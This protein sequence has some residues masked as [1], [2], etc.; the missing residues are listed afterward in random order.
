VP[1]LAVL[2]SSTLR[3]KNLA[4]LVVNK[5]LQRVGHHYHIVIDAR[6]TK[7][8]K[9]IDH[10]LPP[11]LTPHLDEYLNNYRMRFSGAQKNDALWLS[12]KNGAMCPDA[13]GEAVRRR[14]RVSFGHAINVHLFRD[15]AASGAPHLGTS[16]LGHNKP[17]L[18]DQYY[19]RSDPLAASRKLGALIAT[20]RG[21][22]A[23]S[24]LVV[25]AGD[26]IGGAIPSHARNHREEM[27]A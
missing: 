4:A 13:V 8:H 12:S 9:P 25:C 26:S 23:T 19:R 15:I 1:S 21:N 3:R 20:L 10:P 14:T 18:T 17:T 11:E 16:L 2:V 5:D 7:S 27:V 24:K 22:A 6:A